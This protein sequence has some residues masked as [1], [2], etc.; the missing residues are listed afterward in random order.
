MRGLGE[1]WSKRFLIYERRLCLLATVAL[2]AV[3]EVIV[4][5]ARL[6]SYLSANRFTVFPAMVGAYS[7]LLGLAIA[8][9]ALVLDRLAEGRLKLVQA[10]PHIDSLSGIFRSAMACL[11]AATLASVLVLVPTRSATVDRSL[12]YLWALFALLVVARLARVIWI[13]GHMMH[14]VARQEDA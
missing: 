4:G 7:A 11:G 3:S 6:D 10:S 5:P 8:A 14:I 12:V 13:V 1:C 9:S 2:I